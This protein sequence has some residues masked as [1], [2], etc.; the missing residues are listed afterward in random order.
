MQIYYVYILSNYTNSTLYIGVTNDLKRRIYEHKNKLISGFSSKYN[1]NKLVYFEE[2]T[3]IKS[4][5]QREKNLKKWKREWKDE[6]IKKNNPSFY[7]LSKE[8][9]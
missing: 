1:V 3:D 9:L 8:F 5:I 2:T 6:L 4:A 7:D